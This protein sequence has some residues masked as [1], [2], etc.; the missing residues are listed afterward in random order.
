MLLKQKPR[1]FLHKNTNSPSVMFL[2]GAVQATS[3]NISI[4]WYSF[5]SVVHLA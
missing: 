3:F 4:L 2:W 5:T 1:E